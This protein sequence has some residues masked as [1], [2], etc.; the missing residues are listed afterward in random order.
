M[1]QNPFTERILVVAEK[2]GVARTIAQVLV[3]EDKKEAQLL[4]AEFPREDPERLSL[5]GG[6]F[7]GRDHRRG[8]IPGHAV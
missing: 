8:R 7:R 4:H 1:Y 6:T 2:P 3:C 5:R